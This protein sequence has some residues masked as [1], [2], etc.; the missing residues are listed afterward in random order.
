MQG[1]V[2]ESPPA[3]LCLGFALEAFYFGEGKA[4]AA[5]KVVSF[6]RISVPPAAEGHRCDFPPGREFGGGEECRG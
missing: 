6:E 4:D 2:G 5:P 1:R 3:L